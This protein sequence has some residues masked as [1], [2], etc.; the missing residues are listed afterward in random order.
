[1]KRDFTTTWQCRHLAQHIS[2]IMIHLVNKKAGLAKV[3]LHT[4]YANWK[5]VKR[6]TS[7]APMNQII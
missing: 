7:V 1:M 4:A 3:R 5:V 2:D 6:K